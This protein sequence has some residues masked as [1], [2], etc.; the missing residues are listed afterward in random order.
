[1]WGPEFQTPV[2]HRQKKERKRWVSSLNYN[3]HEDKDSNA[4]SKFFRV[5]KI[6]ICLQWCLKNIELTDDVR[7]DDWNKKFTL[8]QGNYYV[9]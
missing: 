5:T 8:D 9:I 6:V 3:I 4:Q 1:V 2:P 7:I